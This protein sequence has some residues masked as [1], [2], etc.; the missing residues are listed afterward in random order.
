MQRRKL[1]GRLAGA[2]ALLGAFAGAPLEAWTPQTQ[3]AIADHAARVA[4]T[5]LRRQME[6]RQW[7]YHQGVVAPFAETDADQHV[8]TGDGRGRLDRVIAREVERAVRAI[9]GHR[10]FADIVQQ[11]GVVSHY[12]ADANNPLNASDGDPREGDYFADY[13]SYVD[14]VRPRFPV[15]FYGGPPVETPQDVRRLVARALERSSAL[16]PAIGREYRRIGPASGIDG[17]DDKSTAF[18][19]GSVAF[20]HAVSDTARVLR[21]IWLRAG[22]ADRSR[23]ATL[24]RWRLILL[25]PGARSR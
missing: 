24:P 25:S 13:L 2:L 19:V 12:L 10:P 22:G 3:I 6:R 15:V 23:L 17:F 18:G 14:R 1:F 7:S 21:Y 11:L 8:R 4:P 9:Q 20:S 5:L 16:Y